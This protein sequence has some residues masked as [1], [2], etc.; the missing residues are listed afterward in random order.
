MAALRPTPKQT[1]C[2]P[3]QCPHASKARDNAN[4][5]DVL[6]PNRT[7]VHDSD[8]YELLKPSDQVLSLDVSPCPREV[9]AGTNNNLTVL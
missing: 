8:E 5:L 9:N 3:R 1:N 7:T 2:G 4:I 6:K